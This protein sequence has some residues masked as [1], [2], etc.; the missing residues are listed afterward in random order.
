MRLLL[1]RRDGPGVGD[2]QA[3]SSEPARYLPAL[4]QIRHR[5]VTADIEFETNGDLKNGLLSL[6]RVTG[7]KWVLL[8]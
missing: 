1:R 7:G 4:R 2:A 3:A 5:G 8:E 6:F